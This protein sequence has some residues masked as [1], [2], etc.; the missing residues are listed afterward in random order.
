MKAATFNGEVGATAGCIVRCLLGIFSPQDEWKHGIR[1]DAWFGSIKTA[2]EVALRGH[3]AVFQVKQNHSLFPKDFI[4]KAL[5][6]APGGVH[7]VLH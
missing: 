1:A 6:D 5:K 4:E 2:N 3:K 7:T